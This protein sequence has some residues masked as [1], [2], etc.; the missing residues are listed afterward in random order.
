MGANEKLVSWLFETNAVRVCPENKP[1]WYTSGTIGPYYINT[2]FLYGSEEKANDLLKLIDESKQEIFSCPG[3]VLDAT[4]NNYN[5]DQIY[6]GLIDEMID[7]IKSN[8]DIEQVDY[9]SGGE[10]RDW[11]FSLVIA[12]KLNKPHLTVYK[13]L[14]VVKFEDSKVSEINNL[15][16]KYVLHIADLITEASSYERA[17]I[18]A[19]KERNGQIKWSVVVVDR[20]QGGQELL[21][22]FGVESY[23]MIDINRNLFEKVLSL[24]YIDSKQFELVSDF[25]KNPKESMRNFLINTPEFL[26]NALKADKKTKERAK[27]CLDKNIYDL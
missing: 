1:F 9:I 27:L 11:F 15:Q 17:W 14:K 8:I 19:I 6:K 22:S 16:N 26:E 13:D 5:S 18:P 2:H 23:S 21:N 10:R 7:F 3:I 12:E 24:G 25:I 20:K 4:L